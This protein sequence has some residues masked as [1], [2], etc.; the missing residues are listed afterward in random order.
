MHFTPSL[1][2]QTIELPKIR[3]EQS[4]DG[5]NR[6][7]IITQFFQ[8]LRDATHARPDVCILIAIQRTADATDNNDA[9]VAKV[10][11]DAGLRAPR[12]AFPGDYID[13]IISALTRHPNHMSAASESDKDLYAHWTAIGD[14][15]LAGLEWVMQT[16][17]R[18]A[19][20][21]MH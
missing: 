10:L 12:M 21:T 2:D 9:Y 7:K 15:P 6:H 17:E 3:I 19:S 4:M 16:D 20:R 14:D 13:H 5:A 8:L 1:N 18:D 11:V